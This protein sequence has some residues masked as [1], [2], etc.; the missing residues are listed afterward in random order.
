MSDEARSNFCNEC[1]LIS[2]VPIQRAGDYAQSGGDAAHGH[3]RKTVS[4][5]E[6]NGCGDDIFAGQLHTRGVYRSIPLTINRVL[7]STH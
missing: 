2:N 6:L 5:K 1:L 4:I 3:I 7:R